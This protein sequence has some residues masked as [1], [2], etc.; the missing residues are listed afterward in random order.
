MEKF[1]D[2]LQGSLGLSLPGV[3][4]ALLLLVVG[5]IVALIIRGTLR[6][7]LNALKINDRFKNTAPGASINITSTI[8][9]GVYYVILMVVLLAVFNQLQLDIVG[10]PIQQLVNKFFVFIPHLI[11]G[12]VLVVVAWLI[13]SVSRKVISGSIGVTGIDKKIN[14]GSKP[15][16]QSLGDVVYWL[17]LLLFLPAIIGVFRLE[18]LLMPMQ[19]M[20]EKITGMV[21]NVL[22]AALIIL[23]G[24]FVAKIV[25]ELV[26]NLLSTT[27][28]NWVGE[29]AGFSGNMPLSNVVGLIVYFF[30]LIPAIIAGLNA[31]KIS[32]IAEPATQMLG[33]IMA[34]IPNIAAAIAIVVIVYLVAKPVTGIISQML[35]GAGFDNVPSK[36]GFAKK[37]VK[38]T[39]PSQMAGKIIFFFMML[40][41]AVEAANRLSFSRVS[42]LIAIMIQFGAQILM[43]SL[44]IAVGLW[45]ANVVRAAMGQTGKDQH[46]MAGVVRVVILGLVFAMGLRAM[47][48]ANDIVNLA[49]GLTLGAA[50]VAV[51]LSFGLGGR[52]AAGR[53]MEYWLKSMRDSS[54]KGAK[55]ED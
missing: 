25:R 5:W 14:T 48:L 39:T 17:I 34:A 35:A 13:A 43:G 18:G 28:L 46:A 42:E 15:L 45:I 11:G 36:L 38:K 31:L 9:S 8:A 4:G 22:A 53:Q 16:S 37:G 49:F 51:A 24:W 19:S 20:V 41:A 55:K 44:I 21:P 30:I 23:V 27:G 6:K 50:A 2:S 10:E 40:F 12:C 26:A 32:A 33:S 3:A 52:E 54:N 47:G 7:I 29:K 1:I